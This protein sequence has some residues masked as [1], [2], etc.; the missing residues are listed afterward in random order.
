MTS[1]Q[2]VTVGATLLTPPKPG[3]AREALRSNLCANT[4]APTSQNNRPNRGLDPTV[5]PHHPT[6]WPGG[7]PQIRDRSTT[8]EPR[9]GK[10][11]N[12]RSHVAAN[13][14]AGA[15]PP[16]TVSLFTSHAVPS[17]CPISWAREECRVASV[18]PSSGRPENRTQNDA[19]GASLSFGMLHS[20][21]RSDP[22]RGLGSRRLSLR[23]TLH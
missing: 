6:Q 12:G 2:P 3:P 5:P 13:G 16:S 8:R 1:R 14:A 23:N 4:L 7:G 15:T 17:A 10:P 20:F 21:S 9:L 19:L 11:G 18:A 22:E